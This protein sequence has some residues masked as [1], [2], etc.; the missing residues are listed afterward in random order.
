MRNNTQAKSWEPPKPDN[1]SRMMPA[2][3]PSCG[4]TSRAAAER[5]AH[6][7][8]CDPRMYRRDALHMSGGGRRAGAVPDG[9][10][11]VLL[12]ATNPSDH[13]YTLAAAG[14]Q[15]A[16][17]GEASEEAN[18]DDF[19]VGFHGLHDRE[20]CFGGTGVVRTCDRGID[21]HLCS[22]QG[23]R[24]TRT[25]KIRYHVLDCGKARPEEGA[26]ATPLTKP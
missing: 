26:P 21:V 11:S 7:A 16:G 25:C 23:V 4:G 15:V 22:G 3:L 10:R 6:L 8:S 12:G 9:A 2:S 20:P 13:T 1:D 14:G 24:R 19:H 5:H 18:A 17:T